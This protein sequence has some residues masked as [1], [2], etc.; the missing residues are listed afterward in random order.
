M[1][2]IKCD[3]F[4]ESIGM[5]TSM[6]VILPQQSTGQIGMG[7]ID[8]VREKYPCLFLLHGL[9]ED[10][11]TWIRRT[12]IERYVA[13][14]GL[15]VVMPNVHR[16]FYSDMKYG[17]NYWTFISEE[18]PQIA[19][20]FFPLSDKREDNFVAGLSMGGYGAFKLAL[21]KPESYCAAA[22]LSGSL[23]MVM[24]I[25]NAEKNIIDIL[26]PIFGDNIDIS[27]TEDDLMYCADKVAGLP[28]DKQPSLYQY[29]GT[30]DILY[31]ENISFREYA[32][33]LGLKHTYEESAGTHEWKY[34]DRQIQRVLEW[35]PLST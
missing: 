4:A 24:Y 21:R 19:R 32:K 15:A 23:D 18:L 28:K 20:S 29:C 2:L 14:L 12:S 35:L 11:L 17:G 33:K 25:K 3:F 5:S 34:W 31:Q 30:E 10:D 6:H 1:A 13:P 27:G 22:S 7:S 16:S 9:S 26:V 8:R